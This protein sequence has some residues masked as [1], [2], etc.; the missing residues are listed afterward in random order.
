MEKILRYHSGILNEDRVC[1]ISFPDSYDGSTNVEKKYPIVILLDGSVHFKTAIGMAHFMSLDRNRNYFMPE[2]IIVVIE[3]VDCER[4]FRITK[5]KTKRPNRMG[6]GRD[7]LNFIE[8]EV[9]QYIDKNYR[10]KP[11]RTLVGHS[12]GGLLTLN[13][14][15]DKNSI[16]NT[17][18]SLNQEN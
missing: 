9:I 5:L 8:K 4:D 6:G 14:F 17:Y 11:F 13:S 7:F 12:L 2:T 18:I 10:T 3:N 15:M 1:L 16:F